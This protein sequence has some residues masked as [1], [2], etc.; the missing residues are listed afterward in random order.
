MTAEQSTSDD[1]DAV[2]DR[3]A[4]GLA[5]PIRSP[6][7]HDPGEEGLDY[8]EL[9]FPSQD[10]IPLEAWYVPCEGSDRLIVCMH[11][12]S[13]SRAGVPAH[14]EPWRSAFGTGLGNDFDVNFVP[15]YRILHDN[16]YHVLAFDFRNFGL[17]AA[18][19]GGFPSNFRFEARDV[20]GALAHVRS[21]PELAGMKLGLFAA[22]LGADSTFRAISAEPRAFD[23]VRCLVAPLLLSPRAIL[24]R[25]LER[26]GLAEHADEVDR[27]QQL[28]TSIRLAEG[29][30]A[31]FA[32][33]VLLPTLTYGV[34]DDA[35]VDRSDLQRIFDRIGAAD[36][37]LFWIHGTTRRWDGYA[38]FQRHPE[39]VL[40]WLDARM[41]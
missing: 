23:G 31:R 11:P 40:E 18:A 24:E 5:H 38:H 39:R 34:H 22:C 15:N 17:S 14:L 3:L 6:L 13:F 25:Q 29:S 26:A 9:S 28:H 36:K 20:L 16:G 19:N 32:P 35:L 21:H 30:P 37:S 8:E 33:D 41:E 10:G 12:R 1:L 27:R 4:H 7:L 2:L